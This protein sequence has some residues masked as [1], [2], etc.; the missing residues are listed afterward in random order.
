MIVGVDRLDLR[1][2]LVALSEYF[3]IAVVLRDV[4]D[5]D[6]GEIAATLAI[7][8]GTVRSRIARGRAALAAAIGNPT[9]APDVQGIDHG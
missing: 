9:P 4:E 8:I 6:Y 3:R 2:V 1:A 5:L 7:P